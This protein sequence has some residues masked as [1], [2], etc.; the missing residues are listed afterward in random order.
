MVNPVPLPELRDKAEER[1]VG[2]GGVV[3]VAIGQASALTV[4]LAQHD[5]AQERAV[6]E[7]AQSRDI[8][9]D[10]IVSGRFQAY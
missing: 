6:R 3:G 2:R 1:F 5:L 9:V 10:F 7:W 8:A 4:F